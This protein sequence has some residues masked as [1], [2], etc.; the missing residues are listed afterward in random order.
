MK[1][2]LI[3]IVIPTY[4]REKLILETLETVFDQTYKNYEI[5][6]VDNASTDSSVKMLREFE[7]D[8][9][10]TL[11][12]NEHNL[13]RARARNKG[14]KAAKGDFLTLLD[15]DDFMA[16]DRLETLLALAT[17]HNADFVADDLYKVAEDDPDGP[18][19]RMFT[20][21][22]DLGWCLLLAQHVSC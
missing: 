10:L 21:E 16:P 4:N 20:D 5:I 12:A 3:S 11:I 1:N 13:E 15:S 6:V 8:G 17:M 22:M 14:F 7:K 19:T 2:P 18:R 9:K